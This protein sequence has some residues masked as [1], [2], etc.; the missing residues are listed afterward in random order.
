MDFAPALAEAQQLGY[1]EA[2]PSLDINGWDTAHKAIILAALAYGFW[3]DPARIFVEG[4][5]ELKGSDIR[6]AA[7]LGYRI[8]LL[9][10][11]KAAAGNAIEVRVCPT[12]IP[13][14]H[15]LA[16]VNGVYNAIAVHGDIVGE[17]LFY[18]RGAGQDPTS[19]SVLGDLVEASIALES[20]RSWYGFTAHDLYGKCQPIEEAISKYYLR[21]S[22]EDRPGVLAQIAGALGEAG[23]GILSVIQ[24]ESH[25]EGT[26]QLV[27]MIHDASF[28]AMRNAAQKIASL[29][30]VKAAPT[31]LHVESFA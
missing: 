20:S 31:L 3:L 10:I 9:A 8:K 29:A 7:E 23:I 2:D 13:K 1:A 11:I 17:T 5:D 16:S 19:S 30:C 22:V 26:A 21:L 28:G 6:F 4:I 15:V 14:S 18:G 27:L 25:Y 24:P 12:L